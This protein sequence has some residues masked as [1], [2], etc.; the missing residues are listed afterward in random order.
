ME[1]KTFI[2]KTDEQTGCIQ[3]KDL[4]TNSTD[5]IHIHQPETV[6]ELDGWHDNLYTKAAVDAARVHGQ[7]EAWEL[8]Q[9]ILND[10][11]DGGYFTEDL[12]AIFNKTSMGYA[13]CA[14]VIAENTYQEAVDKINA[15][16]E[17][18]K[19]FH[20]GDIVTLEWG[21]ITHRAVVTKVTANWLSVLLDDG[22]VDDVAL[23]RCEKTD[24]HAN[25][26]DIL[27]KLKEA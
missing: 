7:M 15:W 16:E 24:E 13:M 5:D 26:E 11:K 10:V 21:G 9:K 2:I 12:M 27:N 25:M 1:K 22:N 8:A 4:V 20:A 6:I 23:S 17:E 3:T 19:A 18:K 14:Q